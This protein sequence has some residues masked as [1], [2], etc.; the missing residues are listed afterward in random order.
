MSEDVYDL[1][2]SANFIEM[3]IGENNSNLDIYTS[4]NF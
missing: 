3:K 1:E 2:K 4:I